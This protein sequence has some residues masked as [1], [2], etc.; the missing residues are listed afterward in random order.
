LGFGPKGLKLGGFRPSR[1]GP[2][3]NWIG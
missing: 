2:R 3:K 1:T